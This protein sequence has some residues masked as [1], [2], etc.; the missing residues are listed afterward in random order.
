[1]EVRTPNAAYDAR[2]VEC[3]VEAAEGLHGAGDGVF[4]LRLVG[5]VTRHALPPVT[6]ATLPLK[7]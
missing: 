1:M 3:H 2:V 4:R 6:K 5:H 7:S